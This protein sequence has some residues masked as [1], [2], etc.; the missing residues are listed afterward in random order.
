[1]PEFFLK[2]RLSNL[3]IERLQ[4][5]YD[6]HDEVFYKQYNCH[7][8]GLQFMNSV[9]SRGLDSM[10]DELNNKKDKE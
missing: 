10:V 8:G 4:K 9:L 7:L 3:H 2:K 5:I 6:A 1:M